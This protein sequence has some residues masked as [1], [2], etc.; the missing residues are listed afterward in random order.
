M[1]GADYGYSCQVNA[2]PASG[3]NNNNCALQVMKGRCNH[4]E[5]LFKF[6]NAVITLIPKLSSFLP[7]CISL[8]DGEGEYPSKVC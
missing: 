7:S 1:I 8:P 5:S 6:I 2:G 4:K 3:T